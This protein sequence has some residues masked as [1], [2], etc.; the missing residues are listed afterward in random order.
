MSPL[1]RIA[2][3]GQIT[4]RLSCLDKWLVLQIHLMNPYPSSHSH[5]GWGWADMGVTLK[6]Q[7]GHLKVTGKS[8]QLQIGENSL[9]LLVLLQFN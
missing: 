7:K 8:N 6:S 5:M 4:K 3:M 2:G 1:S 9:F